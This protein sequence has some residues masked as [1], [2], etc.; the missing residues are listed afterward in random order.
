V[1]I[2][3]ISAVVFGAGLAIVIYRNRTTEPLEIDLFRQRFYI[4]DFYRSLINWTQ[5]L[6]AR[7]AAFFD[8]WIIDGIAVRGASGGTWGLGALMRLLQVGNLQAYAFL[9]GLGIVAMI[10]FTV[11]R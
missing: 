8:R 6:L 10:Y 1:P 11:F 9:F 4:D 5:E 7:I 3:A 2:L